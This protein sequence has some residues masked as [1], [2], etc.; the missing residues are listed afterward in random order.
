MC[1]FNKLPLVILIHTKQRAMNQVMYATRDSGTEIFNF[2]CIL[3]IE[4]LFYL[5]AYIFNVFEFLWRIKTDGIK[6]CMSIEITLEL[7]F[8]T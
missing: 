3:L 6:V 5:E 7:W 8:Q 1:I 4:S 2:I